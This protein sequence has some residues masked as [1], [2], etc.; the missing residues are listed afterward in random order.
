M[1]NN[2][3]WNIFYKRWLYYAFGATKSKTDFKKSRQY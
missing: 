2:R 1:D 3:F